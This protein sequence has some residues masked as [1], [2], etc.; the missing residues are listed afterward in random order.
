[1]DNLIFFGRMEGLNGKEAKTQAMA[2]LAL[3]GLTE[4]AKARFRNFPAA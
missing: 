1:L 2:N 3:M 4:R